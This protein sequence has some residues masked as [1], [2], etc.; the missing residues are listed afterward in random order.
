M[1]GDVHVRFCERLEVKLL[2]ATHLVCGF[3]RQDDAVRV[4]DV[5]HKRMSK[6][7]LTL[8]PDKTRLI[9]SPDPVRAAPIWAERQV[10]TRDVQ[11]P[12]LHDVLV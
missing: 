8:H 4:L 12:W 6:Y 10:R 2:R 7:G 11:L 3:E 5:L 9:P 1:S